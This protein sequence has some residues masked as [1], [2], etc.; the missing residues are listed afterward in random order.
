VPATSTTLRTV[1]PVGSWK[2]CAS[3]IVAE[4]ACGDLERIV[5]GRM[6]TLEI[7]NERFARNFRVGVFNFMRV[8]GRVLVLGTTAQQV[9]LLGEAGGPPPAVPFPQ[10]RA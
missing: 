3:M 7:V 6:P 2:S 8:Q 4:L 9:T 10:V 1:W 5:R